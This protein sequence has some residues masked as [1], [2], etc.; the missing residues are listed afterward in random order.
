MVNREGSETLRGCT[1]RRSYVF[2][3]TTHRVKFKFSK[4]KQNYHQ[5]NQYNFYTNMLH[6]TSDIY[7]FGVEQERYYQPSSQTRR[8]RVFSEYETLKNRIWRDRWRK[9]W[10]TLKI[11]SSSNTRRLKKKNREIPKI[12]DLA[13]DF[14]QLETE[15]KP[16]KTLSEGNIGLKLMKRGIII[17][18][19]IPC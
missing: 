5:L 10:K 16:S 19:L 18:A 7:D 2:H 3:N 11:K 8:R 12:D 15:M 6:A 14:D 13:V 9:P 1:T 4:L 17:P